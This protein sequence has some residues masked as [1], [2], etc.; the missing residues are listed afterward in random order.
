MFDILVVIT[1][2]LN[3]VERL[4]HTGVE[5]VSD[6]G[7]IGPKKYSSE[8]IPENISLIGKNLRY[9][10]KNAQVVTNLQQTCSNAVPTTYQQDVLALLVPSLDSLIADKLSTACWQLATRLLSSTCDLM[11][12]KGLGLATE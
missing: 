1:K 12:S 7:T 6:H 8:L 10:R 9:T 11:V 5:K 2:C 4:A 3:V